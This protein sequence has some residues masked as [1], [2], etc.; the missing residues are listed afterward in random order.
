MKSILFAIALSFTSHLAAD[1]AHRPVRVYVDMVGDL[2]H[3]GHVEFFKQALEHGDELVVG[4]MSD[5]DVEAYKRKT[6]LTMEERVKS[7]QGCRYVSEVLPNCPNPVT[8]EWITKHNIDLVIHGDD[9]DEAAQERWYGVPK[10]MGIFRTV[11]YTGGVSTTD[12]IR[13]I[14]ERA[15]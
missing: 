14:Q 3:Y 7:I 13:R 5:A 2:F 1:E 11:P 4:V 12:I 15:A 6:Y 10:R 8:E 9:F